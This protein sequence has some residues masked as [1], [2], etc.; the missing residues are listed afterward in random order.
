MHLDGCSIS[1]LKTLFLL[2]EPPILADILRLS[3]PRILLLLTELMNTYLIDIC[4][5]NPVLIRQRVFTHMGSMTADESSA[6]VE[7]KFYW[8]FFFSAYL[9]AL[10]KLQR[11]YV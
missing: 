9:D 7:Q 1:L 4:I 6:I 11:L 3:R 10:S 5:I 2:W 8:K